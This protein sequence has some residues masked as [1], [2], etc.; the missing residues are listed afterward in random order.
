DRVRVV[1]QDVAVVAGARLALIRIA[2]QVLLYRRVARHEA[3]LGAG[4]KSRAP[5][6]TQSRGLYL[7]DDLL[8]RGLLAQQPL[9]HLIPAHAA[10]GLKWP[11]ALELHWLGHRE[12][13]R[14]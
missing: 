9:P 6:A 7:I 12:N 3:P 11:R 1:A 5:A 4:G 13:S 8:A 14:L 10:I 2:H